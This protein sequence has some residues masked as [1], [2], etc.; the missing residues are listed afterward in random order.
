MVVVWPGGRIMRV[1]RG[2][3]AGGH[4]SRVEP[5]ARG[6]G[7]V[8]SLQRRPP[9]VSHPCLTANSQPLIACFLRLVP[10]YLPQAP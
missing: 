7:R 6:Q 3:T 5:V 10:T 9:H 1:P 8:A 4:Q 2:T